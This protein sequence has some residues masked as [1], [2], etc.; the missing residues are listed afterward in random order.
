MICASSISRLHLLHNITEIF[1][2]N[3]KMSFDILDK[4]KILY[5]KREATKE[6]DADKQ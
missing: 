2:K 5:I 6:A 4:C 1:R 3:I